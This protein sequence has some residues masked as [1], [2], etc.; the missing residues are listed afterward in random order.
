MRKSLAVLLL[1]LGGCDLYFNGDDDDC[2][3][4]ATG[5][6][7]AEPAQ[8]LRDPNTGTCQYF[9]G[10][11]GYCDEA[12]G[13]CPV[14]DQQAIPDW[15]SCYS[16]CEG[17]NETGC[18]IAPGCYATYLESGTKSEFWGCWQT[19]PSGPVGGTCDGL[20]AYDCSRHDNC[21]A[22]FVSSATG[23]Q[24]KSCAAETHF[25]TIDSECGTGT[26][27]KTTCYECP[28]CPTCG[29]CPPDS[30]TGVCTATPP[31]A[32]STLSTETDCKLR[33]DCVPVYDGMNCTCYPDHCE[34]QIQT[35]NHCETR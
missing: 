8:Q 6:G 28:S 15:G 9:G 4:Y 32:C 11:G 18:A 31:P 21:A 17:L 27:D 14:Y 22:T 3:Y 29:A 13:P 7:A 10:G 33:S 20:S 19:A 1:V 23:T 16:Q 12:C 35:Y 2:K 34:C 26:C 5:G 25:C 24:F 30:C